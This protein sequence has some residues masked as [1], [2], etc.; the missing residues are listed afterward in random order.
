MLYNV[1][2][3]LIQRQSGGMH[4]NCLFQIHPTQRS[5]AESAVNT[6][7]PWILLHHNETKKVKDLDIS[8]PSSHNYHS[9]TSPEKTKC[10]QCLHVF[11][12]VQLHF[13][14]MHGS[15]NYFPNS[16]R[17][18]VTTYMY[19]TTKV[20]KSNKTFLTMNAALL[21]ITNSHHYSMKELLPLGT[22]ALQPE[23]R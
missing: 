17:N 5:T 2:F 21:G 3:V 4:V 7:K 19:D 23:H 11:H 12:F 13:L 1:I 6:R 9:L 22:A 15:C 10:L 16:I 20:C 18:H 8:R 14:L